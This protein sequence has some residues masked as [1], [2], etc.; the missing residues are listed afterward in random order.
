MNRFELSAYLI[1]CCYWYYVK[2]D[3]CE[4]DQNYD[5]LLHKLEAME[6][7]EKPEYRQAWSPNVRVYGDWAGQ[8]LRCGQQKPTDAKKQAAHALLTEGSSDDS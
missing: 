1:N 5:H 8:Y 2:A 7:K 6:A 3:P 4:T